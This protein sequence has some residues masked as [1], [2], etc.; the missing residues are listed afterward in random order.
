MAILKKRYHTK[1]FRQMNTVKDIAFCL[2][3]YVLFSIFFF[4]EIQIIYYNLELNRQKR[5]EQV[6]TAF[7]ANPFGYADYEYPLKEEY[8]YMLQEVCN[9]IAE[10]IKFFP[11][12]RSYMQEVTYGD[13]WFGERTYG[14]DRVHEGT[15]IMS[16]DNI[17]GVIPVVSMTDGTV[18]NMGWLTLG[19]YRI[20]ILSSQGYYYYY[21]HLDS[22]A[23][24]LSIGD[25]VSAGQF[26]GFMGDT[27]YSEVEGTVGNFEVHLHVGIYMYD[28]NGK[29]ISI[30]PYEFLKTVEN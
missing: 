13:S 15:D 5:Y 25:T 27:G 26:L 28:E 8:D 30:N 12:E 17:R 19:G 22:Y 4:L 29:E 6:L 23:P 2:V 11:V 3:L 18:K 14:G 10:E 21:A 9:T 24:N 7:R 20:G 16:N 1:P